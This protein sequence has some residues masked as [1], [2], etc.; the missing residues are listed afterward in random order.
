MS[1]DG[2]RPS[3]DPREVPEPIRLGIG[4]LIADCAAAIDGGQLER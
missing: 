3:L 2:F 4:T 1:D